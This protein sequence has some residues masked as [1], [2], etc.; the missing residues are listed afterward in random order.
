MSV[1]CPLAEGPASRRC[2]NQTVNTLH[3][4]NQDPQPQGNHM[5]ILKNYFSFATPPRN[6]IASEEPAEA[7][8]KDASRPTGRATSCR[9]SKNAAARRRYKAK[10]HAGPKPR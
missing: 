9:R 5:P 1:D 10:L 3:P 6:N 8:G 4:D 7:F 2:K